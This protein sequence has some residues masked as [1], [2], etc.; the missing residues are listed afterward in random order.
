[1]Q[2]FQSVVLFSF[3]C[4]LK[5]QSIFKSGTGLS[6]FVEFPHVY[7][8]TSNL[9]FKFSNFKFYIWVFHFSL[10]N[11]TLQIRFDIYIISSIE[12]NTTTKKFHMTFTCLFRIFQIIWQADVETLIF[13]FK[14]IDVTPIQH[15]NHIWN[16]NIA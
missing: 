6:A 1:M 7:E 15:L 5:P 3:I 4:K 9:N 13:T 2:Y 11:Y 14:N 16:I 10:H 8:I 12:I